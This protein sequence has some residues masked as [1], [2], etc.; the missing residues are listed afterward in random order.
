MI[1]YYLTPK[2][3][4]LFS[5]L[6]L[7]YTIY[8]KYR[9]L[10]SLQSNVGPVCVTTVVCTTAPELANTISGNSQCSCTTAW[11]VGAIGISICIVASGGLGVLGFVTAT[12]SISSGSTIAAGLVSATKVAVATGAPSITLTS[13]WVISAKTAAYLGA[14]GVAT[15]GISGSIGTTFLMQA[16]QDCT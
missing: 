1:G 5:R 4:N 13:K 14:S 2:I 12:S 15:A 11:I 3:N 7:S 9:S 8:R 10:T 16:I 6:A